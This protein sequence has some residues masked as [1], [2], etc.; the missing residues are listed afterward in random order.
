MFLLEVGEGFDY[1]EG[2]GFGFDD[3][4]DSTARDD[5]NVEFGE[6]L[7]GAFEV[8]VGAEGSSLSGDGVFFFGGE[9]GLKGFGCWER[10]EWSASVCDVRMADEVFCGGGT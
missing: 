9:D 5:E 4:F 10:E 3:G 8:G 7:E 6:T 1:A 2:F